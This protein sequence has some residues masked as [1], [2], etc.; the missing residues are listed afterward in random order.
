MNSLEKLEKWGDTHH[1][2]WMDI[3]RIALGVFLVWK[4]VDFLKNMGVMNDLLARNMSFGGFAVMLI[5]HY[6]VF[7]HILGGLLIAIGVLTRFA[8]LIQIPILLGAVIMVNLSGTMF[9]P[10]SEVVI[11]ILVLMLLVYF[12]VIGNGPW[13]ANFD[14]DEEKKPIINH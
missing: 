7:A 14:E 10:Y 6:I 3:V 9:R 5:G 11:S 8:C 1:P 2:K 12:M 4:G 13:A